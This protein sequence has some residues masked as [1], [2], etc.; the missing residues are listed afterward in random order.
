MIYFPGYGNKTPITL[1]G[2]LFLIPF[3]I[4]GIPLAV[5][6]LN[7]VGE[8]ICHFVEFVNKKIEIQFSGKH[9][10]IGCKVKLLCSVSF[11]L[12]TLL[13]I[14]AGIS[15]KVEEWNFGLGLYVWFVTFTTVGFGDYIPGNGAH[16]IGSPIVIVYRVIFVILGLSLVST[17][18][19]AMADCIKQKRETAEH[20]SWTQF[21]ISAFT[22]RK[23]PDVNDMEN[24]EKSADNNN[25]NNLN[26]QNT[27][28]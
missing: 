15:V 7:T 18:F 28:F 24:N 16:D 22:F 9:K 27:S 21:V 3:A 2:Q 1:G 25:P 11:L 4:F 13:V 26:L 8:N 10:K 12:I 17:V 5:F 20:K 6:M 19:N 23:R 14:T